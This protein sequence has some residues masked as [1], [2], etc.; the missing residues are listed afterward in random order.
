MRIHR[1]LREAGIE[2]E[3]HVWEAMPHGGFIP[4]EAPWNATAKATLSNRIV[5]LFMLPPLCV[6]SRRG[7]L[8]TF[9]FM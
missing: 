3:L 5:N 8:I 1:K 6:D 2:A 4:G 7:I 9:I